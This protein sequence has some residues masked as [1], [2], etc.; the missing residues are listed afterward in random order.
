PLDGGLLVVRPLFHL[1]EEA[2]FQHALLQGFERRL[3]LVV[4]NLHTH[5]NT[6]LVPSRPVN[7]QTA[8]GSRILSPSGPPAA[9]GAPRKAAGSAESHWSRCYD[10]SMSRPGHTFGHRAGPNRSPLLPS[11]ARADSS[12][13]LA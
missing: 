2:V 9:V 11:P 13:L 8:L 6:L 12:Q 7:G 3:D 4:V 1:L 10:D 5:A